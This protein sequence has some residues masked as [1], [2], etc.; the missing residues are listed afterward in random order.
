VLDDED[1]DMTD[2]STETVDIFTPM[3]HIFPIA[4]TLLSFLTPRTHFRLLNTSKKIQTVLL[5][6]HFVQFRNLAILKDVDYYQRFGPSNRHMDSDEDSEWS[7]Y[8]EELSDIDEVSGLDSIKPKNMFFTKFNDFSFEEF[9]IGKL[10]QIP[11]F[12]HPTADQ[13][14]LKMQN[15]TRMLTSLT[16]DGTKVTG[17]GLFGTIRLMRN[18]MARRETPGLISYFSASLREL[19]IQHCPNVEHSDIAIYLL[20]PPTKEVAMRNLRKLRVFNAG[21]VCLFCTFF[22][23]QELTNLRPRLSVR[24]TTNVVMDREAKLLRMPI[25][26]TV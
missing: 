18:G 3:I 11:T 7:S 25:M 22:S 20:L 16:L 19:S 17:I 9:V 8:E 2:S 26:L 4:T 21:E 5:D 6:I 23:L 1:D 14:V 15:F 12:I 13:K 10:M 24:F